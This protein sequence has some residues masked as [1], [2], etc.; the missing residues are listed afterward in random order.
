MDMTA[1]WMTPG[2]NAPGQQGRNPDDGLY[3]RFYMGSEL[4]AVATLLAGG[5]VKHRAVPCIRIMVPGDKTIRIER[6][7][8]LS[9]D[10][11]ERDDIRFNKQ[12]TAFK[13]GNTDDIQSGTP[14]TEWAAIN[15]AQAEDL[16]YHGI[17]TVEQL[18][19]MSDINCQKIL[20]TLALKQKA[21][22]WLAN[23]ERAAPFMQLKDENQQL[24]D[25]LE[26]MKAALEATNAKVAEL[27]PQGGFSG[28]PSLRNKPAQ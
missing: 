23:A 4:D 20:G 18:A 8:K 7:A 28:K 16:G 9:E 25:Q 11:P 5:V 10:D 17:K 13:A 1:M 19:A 26:S 22:D 27:A 6:P 12:W 2:A 14:L 21:R 3:V 15:R 24:R